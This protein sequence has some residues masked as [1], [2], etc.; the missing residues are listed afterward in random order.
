M[1]HRN[2]FTHTHTHTHTHTPSYTH[3]HTPSYTHTHTH[4]ET[5]FLGS[6][7]PSV[8]GT[9]FPGQQRRL[10]TQSSAVALDGA[11]ARAGRG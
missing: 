8:V 5:E 3:T 1:E 10:G 4:T 2:S 6:L 7:A 9:T 11:R